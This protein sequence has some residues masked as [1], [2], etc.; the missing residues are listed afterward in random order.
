ML[1]NENLEIVNITYQDI[2]CEK[3][4]NSMIRPQPSQNPHRYYCPV[5]G[6]EEYVD[7]IGTHYPRI[8]ITLSN[9]KKIITRYYN[10]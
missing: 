4:N 7:F 6:I 8:V 5:C 10:D 3:C 1:Y 2:I 9:G